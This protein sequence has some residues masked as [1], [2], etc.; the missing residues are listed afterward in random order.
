MQTVRKFL[1]TPSVNHIVVQ[2]NI[3]ARYGP[4]Q[5]R[6]RNYRRAIKKVSELRVVADLRRRFGADR[7]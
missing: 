4:S 1:W 3:N 5:E 6:L 7:Y 2:R